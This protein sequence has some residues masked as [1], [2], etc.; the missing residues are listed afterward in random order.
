MSYDNYKSMT[1]T[2]DHHRRQPPTHHHYSVSFAT[3]EKEVSQSVPLFV[4]VVSS[5]LKTEGETSSTIMSKL[6][7]IV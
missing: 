6:S 5:R 3:K 4:Y 2:G 7:I 1:D